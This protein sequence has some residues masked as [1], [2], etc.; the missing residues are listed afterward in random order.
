MGGA[1][2]SSPD[3][4]LLLVDI[5]KNR[6]SNF[7]VKSLASFTRTYRGGSEVFDLRMLQEKM[8]RRNEG[9]GEENEIGDVSSVY[10]VKLSQTI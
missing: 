9:E 4:N 8:R 10:K 5:D 6:A 7:H 3:P 2:P 1:G